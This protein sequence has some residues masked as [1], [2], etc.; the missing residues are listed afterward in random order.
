MEILDN[1][2]KV[3]S[4]EI[5]AACQGIDLRGNRGLG[6]GTQ[7][8]YNVIREKIPTL[9]EDKIMYKDLNTCEDIVKSNIIVNKIEEEMG[10]LL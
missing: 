4:M 5:L 10:K 1:A 8:A 7:I 3:V 6:K 2:R 9:K